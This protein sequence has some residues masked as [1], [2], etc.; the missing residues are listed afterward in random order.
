MIC[1]AWLHVQPTA[2][3]VTVYRPFSH[4]HFL[5]PSWPNERPPGAWAAAWVQRT[6]K[7]LGLWKYL[8]DGVMSFDPSISVLPL[9]QVFGLIL[10][11]MIDVV[12]LHFKASTLALYL[13]LPRC[14]QQNK[15]G[16]VYTVHVFMCIH[17]ILIT[18]K[19]P[20]SAFLMKGMHSLTEHLLMVS[21]RCPKPRPCEIP[22]W[23]A[24]RKSD[25]DNSV[26]PSAFKRACSTVPN[27]INPTD[28]HQKYL[29][30]IQHRS[31]WRMA[32]EEQKKS[33]NKAKDKD[34][35]TGEVNCFQ[36]L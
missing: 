1:Y 31:T 10:S 11:F 32:G 2:Y 29:H 17:S 22:A 35:A 12:F 25:S 28:Q 19:H 14:A 8:Q 21:F 9:T 24:A 33:A 23:L 27:V 26:C 18:I 5:Q 15:T 13:L 3:L 20:L 34:L 16:A 7:S 36:R 6:V 4:T 30:V